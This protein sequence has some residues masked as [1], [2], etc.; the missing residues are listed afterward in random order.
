MTPTT[1]RGGSPRARRSSTS[2]TAARPA[3]SSNG[4]SRKTG[5]RR[6]TQVV[7]GDRRDLAEQLRRRGAAADHDH[8][9]PGELL[10]PAVVDGVQLPAA[11]HLLARVAR[12]ERAGPGA[13]GVDQRARRPVAARR[14]RT[15]NRPSPVRDTAVTR[16]G[17]VDRQV[18]APLVLGEVGG[19]DLGGAQVVGVRLER[20]AGQVVHA[21]H[22][23]DG[24]RRP[25]VL[26]RAAGA[27]VGV[28]D[29]EAGLRLEALP[30]QVTGG[31]EP[32]LPGADDDDVDLAGAAH[33]G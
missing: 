26:P 17:P 25:A 13:G 21:V 24:Q 6:V 20:Q 3:S 23:A 1:L 31:A 12:A 2:A 14:S 4:P 33:A 18:E 30:G 22:G 28:E 7:A 19:D 15:R 9:L 10:A 5:G 27:V 11:E 32:G 29:D 16:T 8:A